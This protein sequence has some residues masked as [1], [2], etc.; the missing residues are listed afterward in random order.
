[1]VSCGS[2]NSCLTWCR[3]RCALA[4]PFKLLQNKFLPESNNMEWLLSLWCV[5]ATYYMHCCRRY[6]F[7]CGCREQMPV[8]APLQNYNMPFASKSLVQ[9]IML[10]MQHDQAQRVHGVAASDLVSMKAL[11]YEVGHKGSLD[12]HI[13]CKLHDAV[14][15]SKEEEV[16]N[17]PCSCVIN[18]GCQRQVQ[19]QHM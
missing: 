10:H 3:M 9:H 5:S 16:D 8:T 19:L 14:M 4:A 11:K 17:F 1:M 15:L 7:I 6:N 12:W 18:C 2:R 13:F